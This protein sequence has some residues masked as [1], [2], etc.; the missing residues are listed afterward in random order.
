MSPARGADRRALPWP[1]GKRLP[2]LG[3]DFRSHVRRGAADCV[4]GAVHDGGQAEVPQLQGLA[5]VLVLVHLEGRTTCHHLR[6][7]LG[8][9]PTGTRG[10]GLALAVSVTPTP[11]SHARVFARGRRSLDHRRRG[12]VGEGEHMETRQI[13]QG[14]SRRRGGE[15]VLVEM[16]HVWKQGR[17]ISHWLAL[18]VYQR[19]NTHRGK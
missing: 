8:A 18:H 10:V 11:G 13:D 5:A 9:R 17:H 6:P 16:P 7:E 2:G 19:K 4:E 1:R 12:N 14:A 15:F 3:D